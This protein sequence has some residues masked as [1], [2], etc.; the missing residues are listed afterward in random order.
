MSNKNIYPLSNNDEEIFNVLVLKYISDDFFYTN[1]KE[2]IS[3]KLIQTSHNISVWNLT[4][5][6]TS[7]HTIT[8]ILMHLFDVILN[9]HS[10]RMGH[11]TIMDQHNCIMSKKKKLNFIWSYGQFWLTVFENIRIPSVNKCFIVKIPAL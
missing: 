10:I 3:E 2:F 9:H 11:Q 6:D 4:L 5:F 8:E 1:G 7:E